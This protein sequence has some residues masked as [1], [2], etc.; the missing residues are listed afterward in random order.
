MKQE[1]FLEE[2]R[3]QAFSIFEKG[4]L[5]SFRHGLTM[6][7][8]VGT[9]NFLGQE[10]S[11]LDGDAVLAG[12]Y[13]F[14]LIPP[15][16]KLSAYHCAHATIKVV[17]VQKGEEKTIV[18]ERQD[19]SFHLLVVAEEKSRVILVDTVVESA[20]DL[21][22]SGTEIILADGAELS[23]LTL[24]RSGN[25]VF[26]SCAIHAGKD[27]SINIIEAVLG[28]SLHQ[29][30]TEVR[31]VGEGSSF[32]YQGIFFGIRDEQVELSTK[33]VHAAERTSSRLLMLGAVGGKAKGIVI[34]EIHIEAN[35]K[36]ARGHEEAN[37]LIL[38]ETAN[39]NAI[40]LLVIDNPDVSCGH[41]ARIGHLNADALFYMMSRGLDEAKAK[42][43]I[44]EGFF[45]PIT[46][47]IDQAKIKQEVV[48]LIQ[49]RLVD[50][51]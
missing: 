45:T 12:K 29:S 10:K 5:P 4:A 9:L 42:R 34:P 39:A 21:T 20:S 38:E 27:V 26:S 17:H 50:V 15:L 18:L 30:K 28:G 46:D 40:P 35:A 13:L 23:L 44:I 41:A 7:L 2:K 19:A 48:S 31:L 51:L 49:K 3:K 32:D 1:S 33:V 43:L 25:R 11:I 14:T 8:Q 16:D 37:L 24:K 6:N 47:S 22:T 36:D